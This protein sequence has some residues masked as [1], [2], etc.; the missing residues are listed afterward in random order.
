MQI[1]CVGVCVC[2]RTCAHSHVKLFAP[3]WT[4]LSLEF[5]RQEY[6]SG[7]L[8]PIPGHISYKYTYIPSLIIEHQAEVPVLYH[9]F[10]LATYFLRFFKL[11]NELSNKWYKKRHKKVSKK[12]ICT[13]VGNL[14]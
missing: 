3:P 13:Y 10:P 1:S 9:K 4:P 6:W 7:L 14:F 12:R 2:A 5:S 11:E 8:F